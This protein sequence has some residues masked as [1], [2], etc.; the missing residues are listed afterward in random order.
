MLLG[1]IGGGYVGQATALLQN[2]NIQ[3]K[4]FDV[5]SSK[6][7]TGVTHLQDLADCDLIFICV[8][9]PMLES[10]RCFTGIVEQVIR[11]A[12][13]YLPSSLPLVVRSTVPVGFC[14]C[15]NVHFMPEFLT[16]LNWKNDFLFAKEWI[17]GLHKSEDKDCFLKLA[18]QADHLVNLNIDSVTFCSTKEAEMVKLFRNS[19]LSVKVSFCNEIY[20]FCQANEINYNLIAEIASNDVRIGKSHIRVPGPDGRKGFGGTCFVKDCSSLIHQL[21]EK[22]TKSYIIRAALS[23]NEDI[24][25]PEKDWMDHEH[26]GRVSL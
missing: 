8:P 18:K 7:S 25:R 16:E 3:I 21:E 19:F 15:Q 24:D 14:E 9:T 13:T 12:K 26:K 10:G 23:R 20:Q 22:D 11:D 5:D 1:I 2:K 4:V 17:V 6:C